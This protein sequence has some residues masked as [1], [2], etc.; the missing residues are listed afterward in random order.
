MNSAPK[1]LSIF[2]SGSRYG[3]GLILALLISHLATAQPTNQEPGSTARLSLDDAIE[4]VYT[5]NWNVRD[6]EQRATMAQKDFQSTNSLFLPSL[7]LSETFTSTNDPVNVFSFKLKQQEFGQNDFAVDVLNRP[8]NFENFSTKVEL[9]QPIINIDGW[10]G[11]KAAKEAA[12]A[13]DFIAARTKEQMEMVIKKWYFLAGL[14]D[15]K[16]E[17]TQKAL[18]VARSNLEMSKDLQEEGMIQQADVMAARVR[19]LEL[20]SQLKAAQNEQENI[21]DRIRFILNLENETKLILSDSLRYFEMPAELQNSN[22]EQSP[23]TRSDIKALE[24]KMKA[25]KSNLNTNKS[26]FLPNL[27]AFASYELNDD[28]LFGTDADNYLVGAK[29]SWNVFQGT[30]N[31]SKVQKAKVELENAELNYQKKISESRVEIRKAK[32]GAELAFN[33][34]E[35]MQLAVEQARE[36]FRIRSDRYEEGMESTTDL[37]AA[38]AN[39]LKQRLN[40]LNAL[41]QYHNAIFQVEFLTEQDLFNK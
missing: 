36:S 28:V 32:R 20:E 35:I 34:L 5:Q 33:Q 41:Y 8:D 26:K 21:S 14:A 37:L 27:N 12:E 29:L 22:L 18:D 16:T 4:L 15:K 40:Y 9:Q 3:L 13:S 6:S 24:H 31:L 23:R 25:Q 11:R 39:V 19:V 2:G 38:E 17:S 10:A 1:I 7:T 30:R